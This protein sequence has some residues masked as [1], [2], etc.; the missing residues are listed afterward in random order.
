MSQRAGLPGS[1]VSGVVTWPTLQKVLQA[2]KGEQ[3]IVV[4]YY[5]E[6]ESP[7]GERVAV[8]HMVAESPIP[9]EEFAEAALDV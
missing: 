1:T 6:A 3:K 2:M 4:T 9:L 8:Y 7:E 5:G